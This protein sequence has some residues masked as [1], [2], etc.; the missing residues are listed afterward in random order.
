[1]ESTA[2]FASQYSAEVIEKAKAIFKVQDTDACIALGWTC[3]PWELIDY[4]QK[5][6]YVK[7]VDW[8]DRGMLKSLR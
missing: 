5:N 1:M 2:E 7:L 4:M 6:Y 3:L 8:A